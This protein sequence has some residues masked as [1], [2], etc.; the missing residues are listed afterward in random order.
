MK[1][2]HTADLHLKTKDQLTIVQSIIDLAK[3]E[4][5]DLIIIAGDLFDATANGRVLETALLPLWS[6][7]EGDILVVPGN[8]DYKYLQHRDSVAPNV[9]I[10]HK[11]PYSV[12]KIEGVYFV[13]VPYQANCSLVDIEIPSYEPS[14][15]IT[16]GTFGAQNSENS[17][18]PITSSDVGGKYRYVALGH[19]HTWF[20]K[21]VDGTLVVNPGAPRQTRKTDK[22]LRYVS[23]VDTNTW[24]MERVALSVSFVEYITF[25]L[26]VIDSE[27]DIEERLLA[28]T[29]T[30]KTNPYATLEIAVQGSVV[31]SK[32][33]LSEHIDQWN[34]FL[35]DN[36]ID[37][38]RV[39]WDL[40]KLTQISKEL[41]YA[42][43]TRLLVDKMSDNEETDI[44]DLAPFLF[45]RL[46]QANQQHLE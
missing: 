36:N 10:A 43:F 25:P 31:F 6:H 7:F 37:S 28:V 18:F 17:Y 22:G 2:L 46:Q 34:T 24:M 8:H 26:S 35:K 29:K 13:C 32:F 1:I 30:L 44:N 12:A 41:M 16:H 45:E 39:Q 19:Y 5:V 11:A 4:R 33:S 9:T 15:L 21:W 27:E 40:S 38:H 42:S 20:D 23:L 3:K 14:I